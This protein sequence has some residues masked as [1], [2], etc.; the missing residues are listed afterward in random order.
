MA[1]GGNPNTNPKC[2]SKIS[3]RNPSSGQTV[4]ANVVDTCVGC[5]MYDIDVT[6]SLF[7][8][9]AGGLSAGRVPVDWSA[10]YRRSVWR[11]LCGELTVA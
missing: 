6:D 4:Q 7:A 10:P 5:A 3:I 11:T 9:L 1:N 8:K 2:G